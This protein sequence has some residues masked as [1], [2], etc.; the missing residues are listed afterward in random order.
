M[1]GSVSGPSTVRLS[2]ERPL[3]SCQP[4]IPLC[5]P[6]IADLRLT[7]TRSRTVAPRMVGIYRV[8]DL[9]HV[10]LLVGLMLLLLAMLKARDTALRPPSPPTED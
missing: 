2:H 5:Q 1:A 9:A 3:A 8:G 6:V 4:S 7:T 10:F